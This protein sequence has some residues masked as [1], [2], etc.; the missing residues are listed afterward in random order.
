MKRLR[1]I[2]C[3]MKLEFINIKGKSLVP[4]IGITLGMWVLS[5]FTLPHQALVTLVFAGLA[6]QPVFTIA[7]QT[8]SKLYGVLP[9]KKS[10]ISASRFALTFAVLAAMAV[11]CLILGSISEQLMLAEKFDGTKEMTDFYNMLIDVNITLPAATAIFF[12]LGCLFSSIEFFVLTVFGVAREIIM[13][14]AFGGGL[15]V[16]LFAVVKIFDIDLN[17]TVNWL[18]PVLMDHRIE[19]ILCCIAIGIAILAAV[20][21][22]ASAIYK[23]K[24]L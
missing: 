8:D 14:I 1:E 12:T 18:T 13:S 20:G 17:K 23:R 7:E 22:I 19:F 11:L 5:V 3:L 15:I 2:L 10:S 9:V 6:V 21:A 16:I 24:E 4:L